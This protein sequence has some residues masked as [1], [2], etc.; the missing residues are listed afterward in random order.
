AAFPADHFAEVSAAQLVSVGA[1]QRDEDLVVGCGDSGV[2]LEALLE[3]T[4]ELPPHRIERMPGGPLR[5]GDI[6]ARLCHGI[7]S[8]D[9]LTHQQAVTIVDA[10][11]KWR[12][13][14]SKGTTRV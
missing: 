5:V 11:P 3:G 14:S 8:T 6:G 12:L 7:H 13:Q 4:V 10:S 9:L 2:G 1:Q